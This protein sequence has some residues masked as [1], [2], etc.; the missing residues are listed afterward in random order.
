M[1]P[2]A[3]RNAS[4]SSLSV[5]VSHQTKSLTKRN[6]TN[7]VR[8]NGK[9]VSDSLL[10]VSGSGGGILA[11]LSSD[12]ND[13]DSADNCDNIQ[14][15]NNNQ[16]NRMN[17]TTKTK[18]L[19]TSSNHRP[20][21]KSTFR[22]TRIQQQIEKSTSKNKNDM[23][24]NHN[25]FSMSSNS[26]ENIHASNH[27]I[28]HRDITGNMDTFKLVD[29][30][31]TDS[32]HDSDDDDDEQADVSDE[33]NNSTDS[34]DDD[35]DNEGNETADE[36]EE[37]EE[38]LDAED[39]V[40]SE[41]DIDAITDDLEEIEIESEHNDDDD[42]DDEDDD[43]E[44]DYDPNNDS[45]AI[46][47]IDSN[48]NDDSEDELSFDPDADEIRPAKLLLQ[49]SQQQSMMTT[50]TK[51]VA[52]STK[53]KKSKNNALS[54][55]PMIMNERNKSRK[56]CTSSTLKQVSNEKMIKTRNKLT[57]TNCISSIDV[58]ILDNTNNTQHDHNVICGHEKETAATNI[59]ESILVLNADS[60]TDNDDSNSEE[61]DEVMAEIIP[62]DDD[63]CNND[64]EENNQM[65]NLSSST[66]SICSIGQDD[67]IHNTSRRTKLVINDDNISTNN[68]D[69]S[70][71]S[72]ENDSKIQIDDDTKTPVTISTT[73]IPCDINVTSKK[74]DNTTPKTSP[75]DDDVALSISST[76]KVEY[77]DEAV[78][79]IKKNSLNSS[80]LRLDKDSIVS[81]N[82][83]DNE[84]NSN[85][86]NVFNEQPIIEP[87]ITNCKT[88]KDEN[89]R[90]N[91][92]ESRATNDEQLQHFVEYETNTNEVATK[93]IP[94]IKRS[95]TFRRDGSSSVQRGQWKLGSKIGVGAFGVVHVGMNTMTGTLMAV[96]SIKM[97]PSNMKDT[98][99]E[100]QLLQTLHH[101][102][103]VRYLGSERDTK[104]LHI[105][106]EWV[107][108]GSVTNMLSKFGPF[109][110]SV[111][112]N[113]LLQILHGLQYLH[114]NHIMHRDIKGSNILVNDDGIVKL[115][116]FG[117]S[118]RFVQLKQDMMMSLTMR[119]STY[120]FQFACRI[121]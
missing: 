13:D 46:A 65:N 107:P 67:D 28:H 22:Q 24:D 47:S 84:N 41:N 57:E 4:S 35:D 70:I 14:E 66:R 64:D 6:T 63:D 120:I 97:E 80:S 71:L 60:H 18:K 102:N 100:I 106:Q 56:S 51:E 88:K 83:N 19:G 11:S 62:D 90:V 92:D 112:Q 33:L 34:S 93:P 72:N 15:H 39:E 29:K 53:I 111:I 30:D 36:E 116:D 3:I 37:D 23:N 87:H 69:A 85:I 44:S 31:R 118:K 82:S 2:K 20:T 78:T 26:K 74:S 113:Y 12:D 59:D 121:I 48:D 8:R 25:N 32:G 96:K 98:E 68:K 91:I 86:D 94:K 108:A 49:Q 16:N 119:G 7:Y 38:S 9:Y 45:D 17:Q 76:T 115:A 50:T 75:D 58:S 95:S 40:A 81:K 1:P 61:Y 55:K 99:Q 79:P 73:I 104:Y 117:A 89:K 21:T 77:I 10:T 43:Y 103:I 110:L 109:P 101:I 114:N 105:F 42:D 52:S 54:T 5:S 27:L